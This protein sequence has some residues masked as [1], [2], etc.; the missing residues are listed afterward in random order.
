MRHVMA[1]RVKTTIL[2][3]SE[4]GKS[5]AYAF[6]LKELFQSAFAPKVSPPGPL[7]VWGSSA[8]RWPPALLGEE[9]GRHLDQD[10]HGVVGEILWLE[11]LCDLGSGS[12]HLGQAWSLTHWTCMSINVGEGWLVKENLQRMQDQVAL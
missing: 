2:Y 12:P 7:L 11:K 8:G 6:N 10:L 9:G 1:K 3:A 5:K 4:T